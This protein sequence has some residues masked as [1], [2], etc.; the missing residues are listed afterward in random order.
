MMG[1]LFLGMRTRVACKLLSSSR[2]FHLQSKVPREFH[3]LGRKQL[4]VASIF[5]LYRHIRWWMKMQISS[6]AKCIPGHIRGPLPNPRK[7][8]GFSGF[9]HNGT[10][11]MNG[12]GVSWKHCSV[13][14][15]YV[16]SGR[17]EF[18]RVRED[19]CV[20][21][22]RYD[23]FG[24]YHALPVK[25]TRCETPESVL[26]QRVRTYSEILQSMGVVS[27]ELDEPRKC[28]G[29]SIMACN[30]Q[31]QHVV[32]QLCVGQLICIITTILFF[33]AVLSQE[34]LQEIVVLVFAVPPPGDH[35]V[36]HRVHSVPS[37][38]HSSTTSIVIV[39]FSCC[40]NIPRV[41]CITC[42][43]RWNVVPGI[44]R[45]K[46]AKVD[47]IS[48]KFARNSSCSPPAGSKLIIMLLITLRVNCHR[49]RTRNLDGES[50]VSVLAHQSS[51]LTVDASSRTNTGPPGHPSSVLIAQSSMNRKC[52][53]SESTD[54]GSAIN[55]RSCLCSSPAVVSKLVGPRTC[56]PAYDRL[57]LTLP[58][59][60]DNKILLASLPV[61]KTVGLP[62]MLVLNTLP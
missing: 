41:M 52:R 10:R 7:L 22:H 58:S 18:L 38:C 20:M 46:E 51:W 21:V 29:G 11:C 56:L 60:P 24:S 36:Q 3:L 13:S 37:L 19:I 9:C 47:D 53:L 6:F 8:Y 61:T 39:W 31:S 25:C 1:Y 12:L 42:I 32:L 17:I 28:S 55:R 15:T 16:E 33:F 49:E 30:E 27:Q 57:S 34:G 54:R 59:F 62:K 50:Q 5:Y 4:S 43:P 44:L 2:G 40:L 35:R 26:Q 23:H 48:L 45:G 14:P